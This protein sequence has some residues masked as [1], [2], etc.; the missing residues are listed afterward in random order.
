MNDN[1]PKEVKDLIQAG[2]TIGELPAHLETMYDANLNLILWGFPGIGKTQG[3]SQF[4]AKQRETNKNFEAYYYTLSAQEPADLIGVPTPKDIDGII[5]T[6]WAIP[7][8][9]P[10][11]KDGVGVLF[12]DEYNNAPPSMQNALQQLIQERRLGDY[13]L[14]DGYWIIAAGNPTENAYSTEMQAPTKDRFAHIYIKHN[15]EDWCDYML[16]MP[17]K[18]SKEEVFM[19]N[20]T[21][22]EVETAIVNF[23]HTH[24][25]KLFDED[26]MEAGSYTFAT[27]RSWERIKKL[28][29]K[30]LAISRDTMF[31]LLAQYVGA[32]ITE[33]FL[34]F[35]LNSKKYQKPEEILVHGKNFNNPKDV[36]K[37][38][39][40]FFG[41]ISTLNSAKDKDLPSMINNLMKAIHNLP[42]EDLQAMAGKQLTRNEKWIQHITFEDMKTIGGKCAK[43]IYGE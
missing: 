42:H 29:T 19:P 26:A 32:G 17:V 33:Q 38:Y 14:P 7:Q 15:A 21:K 36:D 1:T 20:I 24:P 12:F 8:N 37:F 27:P 41:I 2:I 40:T 9:L 28:L 13:I 18:E 4:V 25:D 39:G 3:V 43:V 22:S 10:T 5:R 16:G 11:D 34:D 23:I 6:C 35:L 30:N 31:N